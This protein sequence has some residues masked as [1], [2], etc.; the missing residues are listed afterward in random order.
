MK[1]PALSLQIIKRPTIPFWM[2]HS[3]QISHNILFYTLK[4]KFAYSGG[5]VN[6]FINTAKAL[7]AILLP[8]A[9]GKRS[10]ETLNESRDPTFGL[11]WDTILDATKVTTDS[12][13]FSAQNFAL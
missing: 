9:P 5:G 2:F 10:V 8:E 13:R 12:P 11:L 1:V 3:P 4:T 6:V 7:C